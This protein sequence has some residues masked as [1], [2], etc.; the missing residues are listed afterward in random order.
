MER[1]DALFAALYELFSDPSNAA[2]REKVDKTIRSRLD[3]I[4]ILKDVAEGTTQELKDS[5]K[6]MVE[7]QAKLDTLS[8]DIDSTDIRKLLED[9][10][11][12]TDVQDD[13]EA[14]TRVKVSK[15]VN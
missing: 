4:D 2:L 14:A 9:R 6:D 1:S 11:D 15:F 3:T 8:Q 7:Y 12:E 10:E 13:L 5:T